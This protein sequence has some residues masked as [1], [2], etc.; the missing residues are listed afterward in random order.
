MHRL[1]SFWTIGLVVSG[2]A[3]GSTPDDGGT[4]AHAPGGP[5]SRLE[6]EIVF[7]DGIT[8]EEYARQIDYFKIEI[9]AVSKK[10]KIE[11]IWGVSDRRPQRRIG[12]R[13]TD[14]RFNIGWKRGT[15]H[16]AD[17]KL[18][19]KAGINSEGKELS[20]FFPIE[21]QANLEALQRSYAGRDA[22]EIKRTRFQI[23]PKAAGKGYEFFVV[24]QDPPKPSESRSQ[25]TSLNPP[26]RP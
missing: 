11:Y 8:V 4:S 16:A 23:R 24:E 2:A 12:Q 18:L 3:L 13:S 14:Y 19:A 20:H 22:N 6:W 25:S 10:G 5:E 17:R 26:S 9:G 21:V 1:I 15:L 7:D